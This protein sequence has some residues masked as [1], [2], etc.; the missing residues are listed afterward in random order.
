MRA[1]V[2]K[3]DVLGWNK[4]YACW[5]IIYIYH[6]L[7]QEMIQFENLQPSFLVLLPILSSSSYFTPI[8]KENVT[9]NS[10]TTR[11]DNKEPHSHIVLHSH[12]FLL[13]LKV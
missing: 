6:M 8:A 3:V 10:I 11:A 5:Y 9:T 13:L 2:E 12:G 4:S 1:R 7:L